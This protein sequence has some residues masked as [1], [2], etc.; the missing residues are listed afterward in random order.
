MASKRELSEIEKRLA[1]WAQE[2]LDGPQIPDF[3]PHFSSSFPNL[4][5]LLTWPAIGHVERSPGTLSVAADGSGWRV[6]Y[7]DPSARRRLAVVAQTLLDALATLDKA[8]VAP[9]AAWSGGK[10]RSSSFR[11]RKE[12]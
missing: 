10:P 12:Q 6:S 8:V 3:D 9:D 4:W 7:Y 1:Q 5:V 11:K 2:A